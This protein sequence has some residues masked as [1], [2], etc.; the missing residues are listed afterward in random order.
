MSER[1]LETGERNTAPDPLAELAPLVD[2]AVD[3]AKQ[4]DSPY[5]PYIFQLAI[6]RLTAGLPSSPAGA[7]GGAHLAYLGASVP[8][9]TVPT[10]VGGTPRTAVLAATTKIARVLGLDPTALERVVDIGPDGSVRILG[11]IDANTNRDLQTLY[12]LLYCYIKEI[13]LGAR[14]VDI[15]ELRALCKEHGCYDLANFTANFKKACD[16]GLLREISETGGRGRRYLA[17]KR[18]LE[19]AAEL[20]RKMAEE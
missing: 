15:E 20:L 14:S 11:R 19:R 1:S 6:A 17:T 18:G 12:S 3:F 7:A 8:E 2:R 9:G 13:G 16:D 10:S 5:R 4:W